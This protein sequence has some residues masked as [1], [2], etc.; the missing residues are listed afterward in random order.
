MNTFAYLRKCRS[1]QFSVFCLVLLNNVARAQTEHGTQGY[2]VIGH[3]PQ[4]IDWQVFGDYDSEEEAVEALKDISAKGKQCTLLT[5][6]IAASPQ[7][8]SLPVF[9]GKAHLIIQD[10]EYRDGRFFKGTPNVHKSK[11]IADIRRS[12]DPDAPKTVAERLAELKPAGVTADDQDGDGLRDLEE[13]ELADKFAPIMFHEKDEPN[14]PTSVDWFLPKTTLRF[15]DEA[16]DIDELVV[17][18]LTKQTDLHFVRRKEGGPRA[19]PPRRLRPV[20]R[21]QLVYVDSCDSC[22][23]EKKSTFYLTDIDAASRRG[24]TDSKEWITY[25]HVYANDKD[26]VTIQY[27]RFYAYNTGKKLGVVEVGFH[28]GDWEG[29]HVVLD[30][31]RNPVEVA[32]L[33]SDIEVVPWGTVRKEGTHPKVYA[34]EGNHHT[35]AE[36]AENGIRWEMWKDG[37]V[38]WPD[39]RITDHG[40]MINVGERTAPR[41]GQAFIRYSGLWGSPGENYYSSGYWGPAFNET[42]E[43]AR[44]DFVTAWCRDMKKRRDIDSECS[45]AGQRVMRGPLGGP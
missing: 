24:S 11:L 4:A 39:G 25:T 2:F 40:D 9:G 7:L 34:G 45:C 19:A 17:A 6:T 16:R 37:K 44:K 15:K 26:G 23:R 3:T 28:G 13:D 31:A 27:W 42:G 21:D 10:Q 32:Y 12:I 36:G 14:L 5:I 22:D 30:R 35:E 1:L 29:V 8:G 41:N 38:H 33:S 20:L 18:T 43:D